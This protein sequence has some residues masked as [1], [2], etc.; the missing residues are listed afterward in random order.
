VTCELAVVSWFSGIRTEEPKQTGIF[1]LSVT[2]SLPNPRQQVE[3]P[4]KS[5]KFSTLER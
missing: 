1:S 5:A 4:Q 3:N 2:Y